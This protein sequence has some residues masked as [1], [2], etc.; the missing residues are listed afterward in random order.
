[1]TPF[2]FSIA[3]TYYRQ[4][5]NEVSDFTF[6]FPNR[7]AGRFF[8]KYLAEVA[9]KPIFS[10]K[11]ITIADLFSELSELQSADRIYQL[12]VLYDCYRGVGSSD[13]SFEDF[14]F[15]G[16]MLL[17]DF[18]DVDKS[19]ADAKQIFRNIQD[20]REIDSAFSYLTPEQVAI[21]R[22]FWVNFLPISED[23]KTKHD[24]L[25]IWEVLYSLYDS[26]RE[27]LRTEGL[28]YEGMIFRDVAEKAKRLEL[29]SLAFKRLVFI[30]LNGHSRSEEILLEYA[31]KQGLAD[32]Y[33]DYAS[34]LVRDE[35]NPASF[36]MRNNELK[37]PSQFEFAEEEI[38]PEKTVVEVIGIPSFV[39]QAKQV[40]PILKTL[41]H[42]SEVGENH[43]VPNTAI[44]LAD[45]N[46]LL[47]TLY[48]IPE[49]VDKINV[50]MG[51]GL[52]NSSIVAL[53]NQIFEV[54]K[55]F[56]S[57]NGQLG[58][59]FR[60]VFPVL[61]HNYI[62][63]IVGQKADDLRRE[64]LAYNRLVVPVEDLKIHPLLAKIFE[65]MTDS[66]HVVESLK[67]I[68]SFLHRA[69]SS[70]V[71]AENEEE[72]DE[73]E[74]RSADLEC[75]FIV[76]YYKAV[77]R[78]EDTMKELKVAVQPDTFF[79][80]LKKLVAGVSVSFEGEP[81][82]GLQVMGVLETR[83]IDF[84]NL[85]LLSM[86][87]GVFPTKKSTNSFIPYHLRRG[88][89]LP[90]YEH[91]D[92]VFAYHFYRMIFRAKRIFMLYDTRTEGAK[93]AEVSRYFYQLKH[94]YPHH[95]DIRER[96]VVY[97]VP[98]LGAEAITISKSAEITQ[99]LSQ[100]LA[101]GDKA[102]SASAINKYLD[103]PLQF[104]LAVV[105]GLGSEDELSEKVE[106]DV[107]GSIFHSVMEWIYVEFNGKTVTADVLKSILKNEK[108]LESLL[109]RSFAKHYFKKENDVR[110][111]Y[112]QILLISEIL[113]KYVIQ[114][115]RYDIKHTPFTYIESEKRFD[116]P[117]LLPSGKSVHLKGFIDRV[118]E[119]EGRTR[120]IDYKTGKGTLSFAALPDLFNSEIEKRPKAVMQV[121]LYSLIYAQGNPKAQIMP[122]IYF[123]QS[124]FDTSF[125]S[126]VEEK[127]PKG[128]PEP[129]LDFEKYRLEFKAMLDKCLDEI[130][131]P[132]M[133]FTQTTTGKP[134]EWCD[135]RTVCKK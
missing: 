128:T 103:C 19:M 21:I 50:T 29:P 95:F 37:F 25:E 130:F 125:N 69:L 81:L 42:R 111:L 55:N 49:E 8:L 101:G 119:F 78:I 74:V 94:L 65:P 107:F 59:Y 40:H 36:F 20:L 122:S 53:M 86:N 109:E 62:A 121:F 24:F 135:F 72:A 28:A 51:Y 126:V 114:T 99:R 47:P 9:G 118:D 76:Q 33:W 64:I 68:L 26:F 2:L 75:E 45:E 30:G 15:W 18:D 63:K 88:F 32:F 87:E 90:T 129:V 60:F 34:P 112:G 84:E 120:I 16:E 3:Q 98:S 133:P 123:I 79:R 14:M 106:S 5:G 100:Y 73:S 97:E 124:I 77:N 80:L 4:F 104:Y 44:V 116:G 117:Y 110:R 71:I 52:A 102:L 105:E 96:I 48:S 31:G 10:P 70:S 108:Y 43:L 58:V 134:C 89:G 6:V 54:Q 132:E 83:A 12:F 57:S 127:V 91:Q 67:S 82:S 93:A 22:R 27:R 11:I 23:D 85:I 41:I 131:D 1:M 38:Q 39:G 66:S 92:S 115:L 17:N 113:K 35:S 7:R 56:R 13:E 61:T 46:L